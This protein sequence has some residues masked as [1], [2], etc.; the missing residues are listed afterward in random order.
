[1]S[2]S[3]DALDG[4]RA[5][6]VLL[7]MFDH[8]FLIVRGYG[9]QPDWTLGGVKLLTPLLNGWIGVDLFFV[10]SGFL[11]G[12]HLL[13]SYERR[14]FRWGR[15]LGQRVLRIIPAYWFVLALL[16]AG[17]IPLYDVPDKKP[18]HIVLN[19][20]FMDDYIPTEF[21][22]TFWSL[23]VEEKFYLAAPFVVG[24][25]VA[26]RRFDLQLGLLASYVL[27]VLLGRILSVHPVHTLAEYVYV[28]RN[29]F[30]RC[31]DTLSIGVMAAVIHEY[32]KQRNLAIRHVADLLAWCGFGAVI[33]ILCST[34]M[35]ARFDWWDMTGQVTVIGLAFGAVVLGCALGGGPQKLLSVKPLLIVARISYP[36]YLIHFMLIPLCW[37]LV[38]VGQHE[39]PGNMTAFLPLYF[40]VSFAAAFAIHFAVEKPFLILKDHL[41]KKAPAASIAHAP[42]ALPASK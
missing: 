14:D 39:G 12:G 40:A 32:V 7:V 33:V 19:L 3:I 8:S 6:A 26:V 1:V 11:I 28:F 22:G 16:V 20:L 38:G 29:P 15:Y 36:L 35:Y 2:G 24:A 21:N 13:R 4:L 34:E 18:L 37:S 27:V 31:F 41:A 23:G 10:L 42:A 5:I 30:H 9:G 17:L 25:L